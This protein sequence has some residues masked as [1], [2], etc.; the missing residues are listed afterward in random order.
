MTLL[1]SRSEVTE[2]H[3]EQKEDQTILGKE[4]LKL[5]YNSFDYVS[6][7]EFFKLLTPLQLQ[8]VA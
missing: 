1:K 5:N 3:A 8:T 7:S 6:L 4:F 2:V